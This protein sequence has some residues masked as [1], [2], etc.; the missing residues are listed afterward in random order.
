MLLIIHEDRAAPAELRE[1]HVESRGTVS[2]GSGKSLNQCTLSFVDNSASR[3]SSSRPPE[4]CH[5][6][7]PIN[8]DQEAAHE[9]PT[10]LLEVAIGRTRVL[11]EG[12]SM[13][14]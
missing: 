6:D 8:M 11:K 4:V 13:N 5:E 2:H 12:K 14:C 9:E 7:R 3:S 10:S 1:L